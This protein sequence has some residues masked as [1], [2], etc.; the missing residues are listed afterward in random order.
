LADADQRC[1]RRELAEIYRDKQDHALAMRMAESIREMFPSC[2][3]EEARAIAGHTSIRSSGRVGRTAAGQH[4]GKPLARASRKLSPVRAAPRSG[5]PFY[6]ST[7]TD[8]SRSTTLLATTS[9]I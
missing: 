6:A 2:P 1:T 8:S 7:S 5:P 4:T 9:V 3:P